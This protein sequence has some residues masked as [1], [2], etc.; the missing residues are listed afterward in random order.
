MPGIADFLRKYTIGSPISLSLQ[1]AGEGVSSGGTILSGSATWNMRIF[2]VLATGTPSM[3]VSFS[4]LE[5][6]G[7]HAHDG[8]ALEGTAAFGGGL[9]ID[10]GQVTLS[11][12]RVRT[13]SAAGGA[14][15]KAIT[16]P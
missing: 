4:Y 9:L 2:E 10:G 7:G 13:N 6:T 1:T 12:A 5:I 15:A 8:G 16:L 14:G 11:N 3:K